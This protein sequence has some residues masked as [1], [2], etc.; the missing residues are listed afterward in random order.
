MVGLVDQ[1]V[2]IQAGINHDQVN[3]IINLGGAGIDTA[4]PVGRDDSNSTK[5]NP[6]PTPRRRIFFGAGGTFRA[7]VSALSASRSLFRIHAPRRQIGHGTS[8]AAWVVD[9]ELL[10]H[11]NRSVAG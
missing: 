4:K 8:A 9:R 11:S 2:C 7:P 6:L 3:E 1:S 5:R 10:Q